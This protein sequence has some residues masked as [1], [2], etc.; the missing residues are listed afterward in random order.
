MALVLSYLGNLG[1]N[2]GPRTRKVLRYVGLVVLALVSFVFAFQM[3]FPFDRVKDKVIEAV[4][5]KYDLTIGGVERGIIPGRVYFKAVTLRFRPTKPTDVAT[6]FFMDQVEVDLGL[7]ALL[8]STIAVKLDVKLGPGHIKG[9]LA[10][11]S[12]GTSIHATGEDLPSASLPVRELGL[13]MSGKVRFSVDLEVP[14]EKSKSGKIAANWTKAEGSAEFACPSGCTIGDGKSKLKL[15]T[16]NARQQAFLDEGGG[17]I[18]FG[19]VNIESLVADLELK[20]GTLEITKFDTKS[21]DGELH[22]AFNMK[23]NQDFQASLIAGCLRFRGSDALLKREPKT[24]AAISTTGAPLGPDNLFHIK[25]D[26]PVRALRRIGVVCGSAAGSGGAGGGD[27]SGAGPRPNLTINPDTPNPRPPGLG[28][29]S[30]P[31]PPA[32]VTPP[33]VASPPPSPPPGPPPGTPPAAAPETTGG[34]AARP[35]S[36]IGEAPAPGVFPSNGSSGVAPNPN[37]PPQPPP[38]A[39]TNSPQ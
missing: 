8:R 5:D 34:D 27:S 30:L 11:S 24:H 17:G 25:L 4:E 23:L 35:G 39:N 7:F 16:N 12:S 36:N 29:V 37:Q 1:S 18:D 26:G 14:N 28:S 22:I 6:T 31:P 2:L 32:Q 21:S 15:T 3:T 38:S 20:K 13:P 19:K 33:P 9:R 10:L